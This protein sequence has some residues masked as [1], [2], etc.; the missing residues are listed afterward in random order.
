M[1]RC[2]QHRYKMSL[3]RLLQAMATQEVTLYPD[4]NCL[5]KEH[6]SVSKL[7]PHLHSTDSTRGH[8]LCQQLPCNWPQTV[9]MSKNSVCHH[10]LCLHRIKLWLPRTRRDI[11]KTKLHLPKMRLCLPK[12]RFYLPSRRLCAHRRRL[13]LLRLSLHLQITRQHLHGTT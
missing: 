6:S 1:E 9:Y 4:T 8:W 13:C 11:P 3:G 12:M 2:R 10:R 5:Y 7:K